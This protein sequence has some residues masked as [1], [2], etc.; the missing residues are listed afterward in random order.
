VVCWMFL[1]GG[2][3]CWSFEMQFGEVGCD[4][5][6]LL[7]VLYLIWDFETMTKNRRVPI[8]FV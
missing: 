2:E 1:F 3:L 6:E 5:L 8:F 7:N 4:W